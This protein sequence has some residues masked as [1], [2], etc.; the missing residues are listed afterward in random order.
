VRGVSRAVSRARFRNDDGRK[1]RLRKA[2]K[3]IRGLFAGREPSQKARRRFE[4]RACDDRARGGEAPRASTCARTFHGVGSSAARARGR[5]GGRDGGRAPR[6]EARDARLRGAGD[7]A[8]AG[9]HHAFN[10]LGFFRERACVSSRG[11]RRRKERRAGTRTRHEAG[12]SRGDETRAWRRASKCS[13]RGERLRD[14]A[15]AFAGIEGAFLKTWA[16][17]YDCGAFENLS[18]LFVFQTGYKGVV[19]Y[20][21]RARCRV[22][23][24]STASF[25]F[26]R[27]TQSTFR[28]RRAPRSRTT[29]K[30]NDGHTRATKLLLFVTYRTHL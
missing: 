15:A 25:S 7:A 4:R 6:G 12:P 2:K 28:R 9:G 3:K 30:T 8:R 21:F 19:R 10:E 29:L 13:S 14:I 27:H 23:E 18:R 16:D 20:F 22:P 5:G 1:R 17:F 26:L 11:A 24:R